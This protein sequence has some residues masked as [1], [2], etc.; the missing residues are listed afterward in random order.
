MARSKQS[1]AVVLSGATLVVGAA[2][3]TWSDTAQNNSVS[4]VDQGDYRLTSVSVDQSALELSWSGDASQYRVRVGSNL[5]NPILDTTTKNPVASIEDLGSAVGQTGVVHYRIENTSAG[6]PTTVLSGTLTLPPEAVKKPRIDQRAPN[7]LQLSWNGVEQATHYDIGI[8]KKASAEPA[9]IHRID[10]ASQTHILDSLKPESSGYVR[11]RAVR[12]GVIGPFSDPTKFDTYAEHAEIKIGTWNICSTSCSGFSTR[13][14]RQAAK[15]NESQIDVMSLQEAGANGVAGTTNAKFTGGD[16][17]LVRADGG[18]ATR[19]IFYRESRLKQL[20]GGNFSVGNGRVIAWGRFQVRESDQSF[21]VV[22]VHLS[23]GSGPKAAR[24]HGAEAARLTSAIASINTHD[25]PVIISGDY[26][27]GRHKKGDR[28]LGHL[29]RTGYSNSLH[30]AEKT[31]GA[32]WNTYN[33]NRARLRTSGSHIDHIFVSHGVS[34]NVWQQYNHLVNGRVLSDHNM[35]S[36]AVVLP[37]EPVEVDATAKSVLLP[38][39]TSRNMTRP[40]R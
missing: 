27:S 31:I 29:G 17:G 3:L 4:A 12:D 39:T 33:W 11:V 8:S 19:Y 23:P 10:A 15:V 24:A 18:V 1:L 40:L 2:A 20:D 34:V 21:I 25:D 7:G 16:L 5:K 26:N 32:Q 30:I 37:E 38:S 36:A 14:G 22:N 13:S 9:E 35:L 28:V 6:R